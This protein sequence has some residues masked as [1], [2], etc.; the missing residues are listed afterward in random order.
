MLELPIVHWLVILSALISIAGAC[1]YIRDTLS[2]KTKPNLVSWS[3]WA[4]APLIGTAA[5]VASNADIWA[6][7]RIFLAGFLPLLVILA[8]FRNSQSYWKLNSFDLLCGVFSLIALIV[9]GGVDSPRMAILLVAVADGFASVPT[10]VKAWRYPETETGTTYLASFISVAL[11]I[12]SIPVWNIEN[13][14]FQVYLLA[15]NAL[16]V[17][18]I[19][20][21]KSNPIR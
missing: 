9:W 17:M 7:V 6:T 18:L 16:L 2:G 12:P 10:V 5:A 1:A 13:S 15:V 20:R 14:A 4:L 19:Y 11:V 3:M 8:S 21:R